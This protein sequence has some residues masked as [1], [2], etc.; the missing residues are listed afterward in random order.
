MSRPRRTRNALVAA[1]ALLA[2]AIGGGC[3]SSSVGGDSAPVSKCKAL[4]DA[5]CTKVVDCFVSEG[6]ID[7]AQR[8]SG[9]TDC[10]DGAAGVLDC[11]RAVSV[12]PSYDQCRADIDGAS[13]PALV[14]D[15]KAGASTLPST[16]SGVILLG[17]SSSSSSSNVAAT[18]IPLEMSPTTTF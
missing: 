4:I 10:K 16:C 5:W 12:E 13:C 2:A 9:I 3:S 1:S 6:E 15:A 11:S 17:G 8:A 14:A 18:T 7:A